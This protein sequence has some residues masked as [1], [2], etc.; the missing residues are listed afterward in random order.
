MTPIRAMTRTTGRRSSA[1]LLAAA[2]GLGACASTPTQ[3]YTLMPPPAAAAAATAPYQIEVQ[4]VDVPPQVATQ[5]L[6]VRTSAGG[7]VPVDTRRWIAPLG[8]EIRDALSAGLS[9]RLGAHEVHGLANAVAP[10]GQGLPTWRVNL[11]VQRF[12]SSLG[13]Y[14]RI[15]ALW[16]LRRSDDGG[17]ALTCASSVSESVGPG[18]EALA[19]GH[20]RAVAELAG[21]IAAAI[22]G[23]A[24]GTAPNCPP[25]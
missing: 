16:T 18:Y 24:A 22:G 13:A 12:E 6:V 8:D 17:A 2:L 25:G 1:A 23:A 14:A 3:F 10:K 20:Q 15:D 5:Q 19:E 21:R 11:K 9:Q 4:G 7:M